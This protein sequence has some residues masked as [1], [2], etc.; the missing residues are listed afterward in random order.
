MPEIKN[1]DYGKALTSARVFRR[2]LLDTF[3]KYVKA[4][5]EKHGRIAP[6]DWKR[7]GN[8]ERECDLLQQLIDLQEKPL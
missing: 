6:I 7:L 8:I 5:E 4:D 3:L 2:S 1:K